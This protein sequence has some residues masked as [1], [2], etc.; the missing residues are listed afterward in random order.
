MN[1]DGFLDT[2]NDSLMDLVDGGVEFLPKLFVAVLL[3]MAGSVISRGVANLVGK[4]VVFVETNG[5][6]KSLFNAL[7]ISMINISSVV[8]VVLRWVIMLI[9]ISAAV[10]IL[11]LAVLTDT[12]NALLGFV[13]N[14]FA[15]ALVVGLS[16]IAGNAVR[17]IVSEA[18][19]NADVGHHKALG[20]AARLAVLIFGFPL[21]AAQL[22]FDM[23]II[24]NNLTVIVAGFMLA[25][26][27]AFGLGGREIAAKIVEDVYKKLNSKR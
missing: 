23:T 3:L 18:A 7:G 20:S 12:F 21:A 9:F 4:A 6:V 14:I 13:P 26:G 19:H 17:S 10:D 1:D 11:G 22:G 27:L 5:T 15:A 8:T 16:L 2:I 25:F 24:N